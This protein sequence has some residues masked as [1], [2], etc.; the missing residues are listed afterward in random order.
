MKFSLIAFS[1]LISGL[2][3]IFYNRVNIIKIFLGVE[4]C[5]LGANWNFV[6]SALNLGLPDSYSII[7]IVLAVAAA[8]VAIGLGL[9]VLVYYRLGSIEMNQISRLSG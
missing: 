3:T 9:M 1:L 6:Y 4:L 8:E 7:L 2:L 5:L